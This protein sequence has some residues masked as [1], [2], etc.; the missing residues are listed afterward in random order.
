MLNSIT[1]F[2]ELFQ[3]HYKLFFPSNQFTLDEQ[4]KIFFK[5]GFNNNT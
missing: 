3:K 2:L 5:H 1:L 4:Q